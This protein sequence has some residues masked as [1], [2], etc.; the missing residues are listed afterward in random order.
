MRSV[1]MKNPLTKTGKI[2]SVKLKKIS[3]KMEYPLCK[4]V[5]SAV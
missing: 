4:N 1:K 3:V 2:C 5:I